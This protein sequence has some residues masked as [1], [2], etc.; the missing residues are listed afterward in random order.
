MSYTE[1]LGTGQVP[2]ARALLANSIVMLATEGFTLKHRST[3]GV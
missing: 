1:R 3:V 2:R